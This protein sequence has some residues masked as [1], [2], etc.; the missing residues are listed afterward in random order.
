MVALLEPPWPRPRPL[1]ARHRC[2]VWALWLRACAG[3]A[4]AG[5][6]R[7]PS[8]SLLKVEPWKSKWRNTKKR[9][10]KIL[11]TPHSTHKSCNFA[12]GKLLQGS[13]ER[14]LVQR[15]VQ[16]DLAVHGILMDK[17]RCP[18]YLCSLVTG[19]IR[20]QSLYLQLQ[21]G[22]GEAL[23]RHGVHRGCKAVV[24]GLSRRSEAQRMQQRPRR[25]ANEEACAGT[26]LT[27][28]NMT[29]HS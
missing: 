29:V 18:L 14:T 4:A 26:D 3:A 28:A 11:Q 12:R 9:P 10:P 25:Q 23:R 15:D 2:S 5:R 13:F 27:F 22:G 17:H 8:A 19:L 6:P 16:T 7:A 20:A 1:P 21:G 24:P